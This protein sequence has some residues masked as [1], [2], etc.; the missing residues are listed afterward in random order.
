MANAAKRPTVGTY[1]QAYIATRTDLKPATVYLLG[2]TRRYLE[3]FLGAS[4]PIDRITRQHARDWRTALANGDLSGGR[5]MTEVSV[6]DRC[7]DAKGMFKRGVDDDLILFNPFDRLKVRAPK[8]DKNW[9][10][11]TLEQLERLLVACPNTGWKLLIA[12]CRLAGLRRGEALT[13]PW[14]AVDWVNGRLTVFSQK[15]ER[16]GGNKRIVPIEPTLLALLQNARRRASDS[17]ERICN[18]SQ[19]CLW[20]NFI[21]IR[22]RAGLPEWDDAFQV[23][24]R[25]CETDWAQRFPQ[26]AV[27]EWI[28]HDITVSAT[29][30]LKVPEELYRKVSGCGPSAFEA[31]SAPKSAPRI[32]ASGR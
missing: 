27:S 13:L 21:V 7:A 12:L 2:L 10:Y 22:R 15:T 24:R 19:H 3:R 23:M 29:Y 8:P 6:C 31:P 18:I 11:V 17:D 14:S 25:N 1:L 9:H 20:R 5:K 4:T 30:Y 32:Q 16:H 26:Y 28:G